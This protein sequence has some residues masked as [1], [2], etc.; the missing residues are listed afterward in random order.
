[1]IVAF[2]I[3]PASHIVASPYRPPVA[4]RWASSVVSSRPPDAPSGWPSAMAPPR[5]L[6][7]S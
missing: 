2:A 4:S 6:T 5:G 7:R 3:P 1:M